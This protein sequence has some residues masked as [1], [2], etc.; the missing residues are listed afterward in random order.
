M[1]GEGGMMVDGHMRCR[2]EADLRIN[3]V[4]VSKKVRSS[5]K[6]CAWRDAGPKNEAEHSPFESMILS[7]NV[8]VLSAVLALTQAPEVA[9]HVRPPFFVCES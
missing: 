5:Q 9:S 1:V 6:F 2:R 7:N 3:M 8:S 4:V